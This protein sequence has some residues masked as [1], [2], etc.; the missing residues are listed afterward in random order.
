MTLAPDPPGRRRP[1]TDA[2]I[3]TL[4]T[5]WLAGTDPNQIAELLGR[6]PSAVKTMAVRLGLAGAGLP[7]ASGYLA[8]PRSDNAG[9]RTCMR[10]RK[11]FLSSGPSNRMCRGCKRHG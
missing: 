4:T 6:T 11:E 10:C 5:A 1:W 8:R 7:T 3:A 9:M 2:D